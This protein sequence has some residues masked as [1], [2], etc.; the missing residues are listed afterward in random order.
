MR[1]STLGPLPQGPRHP[2]VVTVM[3]G[4]ALDLDLLLPWTNFSMSALASTAPSVRQSRSWHMRISVPLDGM[5]ES[6][7][8][9]LRRLLRVRNTN[10]RLHSS[11]L[12]KRE[13]YGRAIIGSE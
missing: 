3:G 11:V 6:A 1:T 7:W 9:L 8:V 10:S 12:V 5:E 4:L 13:W 2:Q